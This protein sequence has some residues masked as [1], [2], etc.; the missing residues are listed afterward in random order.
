M[1]RVL[2]RFFMRRDMWAGSPAGESAFRPASSRHDRE[3]VRVLT[4]RDRL[5]GAGDLVACRSGAANLGCSRLFRR[6]STWRKTMKFLT[7][8]FV[9]ASIIKH[10]ARE[11]WGRNLCS[12]GL[13]EHGV[14]IKVRHNRYP[15]YW[16]VECKGDA[17]ES[18]KSPRSHREV[19]FNLALGQIITRMKSSGKRGYK[20]GYKYGVGFPESWRDR[21]E[22]R[23]PSNVADRLNL[24][25]VLVSETGEVEMLDWKKLGKIQESAGKA[26]TLKNSP[27]TRIPAA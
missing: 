4:S 7:E 22:R 18:A 25:V 23:L 5:C 1:E 15:R 17:S 14:D 21:A 13:H 27:K 2:Y 24:Y 11:D 6:P 3:G 19:H 10:L 20:Y 12:K 26:R 8:E 9:I 16:L